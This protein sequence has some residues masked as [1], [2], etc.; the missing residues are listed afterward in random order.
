MGGKWHLPAAS[1]VKIAH[2]SIVKKELPRFCFRVGDVQEVLIKDFIR[3]NF[4]A[5]L[6]LVF[7]T[8]FN[9]CD[10]NEND[11]FDDGKLVMHGHTILHL[12]QLLL[13]KTKINLYLL[14]MK[15]S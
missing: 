6:G 2:W 11:N 13:L 5:G 15:D 9:G 10:L 7:K 1:L 4:S 8:M 3:T 14:G 12:E